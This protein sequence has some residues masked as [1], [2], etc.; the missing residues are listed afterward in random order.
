MA[1][2]RQPLLARDVGLFNRVSCISE[3]MPTSSHFTGRVDTSSNSSSTSSVS[4]IDETSSLQMMLSSI[5]TNVG[6]SRKCMCEPPRTYGRN[7][8]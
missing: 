8:S 3:R 7:T 1:L 4:N 5:L 6:V 2:V